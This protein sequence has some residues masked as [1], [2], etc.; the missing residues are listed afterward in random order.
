MKRL[1]AAL[2]LSATAFAQQGVVVKRLGAPDV[3]IEPAIWVGDMLYVCGVMGTPEKP[4][5]PPIYTS[6]TEQQARSAFANIGKVLK[7]QGLGLGDIVQMQVFLKADPKT[8]VMDRAGMERAYSANFG[9]KEQPRK[10]VRA[11]VE[12]KNLVV[13]TGLIE[14]MVVAARPRQ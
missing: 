2:L 11:T 13:P 8:G 7:E 5:N 4:G 1:L 10:P 9:S 12:V 3:R 14:V 6:D